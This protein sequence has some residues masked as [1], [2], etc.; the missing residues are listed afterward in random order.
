MRNTWS[1]R[2]DPETVARRVAGRRHYNA[3]RTFRAALRRR[4][5]AAL[6]LDGLS[7]SDIARQLGVH[8][9]TICRDMVSL[10]D[11]ARAEVVCP[12]CGRSG[13]RGFG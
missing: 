13:P 2:T 1:D 6:L 3:V 7:Q 5:V 9:S 12:V 4:E 8:R 10:R 11:M